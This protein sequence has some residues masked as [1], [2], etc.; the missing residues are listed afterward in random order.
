MIQCH[1]RSSRP[2]TPS[3]R[4]NSTLVLRAAV[5]AS[6]SEAR[7]TRRTVD[8]RAREARRVYSCGR[9]FVHKSIISSNRIPSRHASTRNEFGSTPVTTNP[10]TPWLTRAEAARY[11]R[12]TPKTLANMAAERRGP[13]CYTASGAPLYH[14]GDLEDFIRGVAAVPVRDRGRP[15]TMGAAMR[16]R[17]VRRVKL[18]DAK[19]KALLCPADRD[20]V[21]YTDVGG[22]LKLYVS[23]TGTKVW[24]YCYRFGIATASAAARP[25]RSCWASSRTPTAMPRAERFRN[26]KMPGQMA[27]T[28]KRSCPAALVCRMRYSCSDRGS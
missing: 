19:A 4:F 26:S 22:N 20:S 17:D 3:C 10:D 27:S 5:R 16:A 23:L 21:T 8:R 14:V 7:P 2:P 1:I 25:S 28:P 13:K 9:D 12:R 15:A 24:R 6:E 18:S 11:I